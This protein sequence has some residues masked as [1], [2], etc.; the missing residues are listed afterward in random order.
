MPKQASRTGTLFIPLQ[1][2]VKLRIF[3]NVNQRG[4]SPNPKQVPVPVNTTTEVALLDLKRRL[5]AVL[6]LL[7]CVVWDGFTLS[8]G[9]ELHI[10]WRCILRHGPSSP[11]TWDDLDIRPEVGLDLF[12]L[13]RLRPLFGGGFGVHS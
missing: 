12:S 1:Q 8:R 11:L 3:T 6:D 2:I 5:K 7:G 4:V 9:R 13:R 10:Q